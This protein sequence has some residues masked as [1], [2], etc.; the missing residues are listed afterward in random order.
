MKPARFIAHFDIDAFYAS[1]AIRDDPSLAGK[2]VAIAGSHR[3]SVVLTA[4]YEARPYG[5]RS[6]IPLYR[7]RELCPQLV[8]VPP[9]MPK[10]KSVSRDVFA[11]FEQHADAVEGLSMDEAFLDFGETTLDDAVER[12]QSIRAAVLE[13]TKLTLSAGVATGKLIA[14]IASDRCKPNGLLAVAPGDEESF[15]APLPAKSLW[16]IG[17]KTAAR[18][19]TFGIT[20]IAQIAALDDDALRNL[21]G[22]WGRD[23]RELARGIDNRAVEPDRETKSISSE[24]TFEYDVRDEKQLIAALR[25]QTRDVVAKMEREN[26]S[27]STVGVKIKRANFAVFGRQTHL[28]EPTRDPRRIFRAAV[29]CLQRAHLNGAPVRLIGLRVASFTQ[30]EP[31]QLSLFISPTVSP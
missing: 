28:E 17:P 12:A 11:I 23:V 30:G 2:P 5:V 4:S 21:F 3:R 13:S 29:Y 6:A 24:E 27:A 14:K 9:D 22:S 31:K 10:Y 7:A 8:V 18:L 20:T 16:G 15:L 26:L 1:V 25:E 19:E